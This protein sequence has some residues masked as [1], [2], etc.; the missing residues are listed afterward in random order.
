MKAFLFVGALALIAQAAWA[1]PVEDV[2]VEEQ[3]LGMTGDEIRELLEHADDLEAA[4]KNPGLSF[5]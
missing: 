3:S 2:Q 4:L 1:M 5:S